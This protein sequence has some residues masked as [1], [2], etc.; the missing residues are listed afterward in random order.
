MVALSKPT[1][2]SNPRNFIE[3]GDLVYFTADDGER[4]IALYVTDGT[5]EGTRLVADIND[6]FSSSF[7][8]QLPFDDQ[9]IE[10]NG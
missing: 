4:D 3:V 6:E 8:S 2:T 10:F 9:F 5:P 1:S 7:N